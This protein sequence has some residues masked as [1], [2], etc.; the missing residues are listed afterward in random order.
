MSLAEQLGD[1][2]SS[3]P[4]TNTAVRTDPRSFCSLACPEGF[5]LTVPVPFLPGAILTKAFNVRESTSG[6]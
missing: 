3:S 2:L 4:G 1:E 6:D 5:R